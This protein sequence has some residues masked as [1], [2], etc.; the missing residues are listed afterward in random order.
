MDLVELR[1]APQA[2][3]PWETSRVEAIDNLVRRA[4]AGWQRLL[5]VGCGDGY[6][7]QELSQ[8]LGVE[9][10]IGLDI[11]LTE[12]MASQLSSGS[13]VRF[14]RSLKELE[15]GTA[16]LILLLDVLEHV[17]DPRTLLEELARERLAPGGTLLITVPAFQSLFTQH[18]VAL[19]HLR[20]YSREQLVS[21]V[22]S[23]GLGV[24]GSGYLFSSLLVP[25]ALEALK[26]RLRPPA[27]AP[28]SYGVGGWRA[29]KL[30]TRVVHA[31]LTLD[32]RVC[33]AARDLG[34]TLP[35]LS[36]WLTCKA[37]S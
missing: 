10:A 4:G 28:A 36:V 22:K 2:R 5:D 17:E 6:L 12:E 25:R 7:V 3:H 33:L 27:A 26:E 21:E 11:H 16:D 14:V 29:P 1:G 30:V 13:R 37:R 8:R 18:D 34:V 9:E 19:Q 24:V 32:N 35:G 15:A 20:R 31:A 23:A